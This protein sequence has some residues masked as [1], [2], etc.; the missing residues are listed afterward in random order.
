MKLFVKYLILI[1]KL[2]ELKT[3]KNSDA[4]FIAAIKSDQLKAP[5][6]KSHITYKYCS[7]A[8]LMIEHYFSYAQYRHLLIFNFFFFENM[9]ILWDKFFGP[10]TAM[11]CSLFCWIVVVFLFVKTYACSF[12][13]HA[14]VFACAYCLL[15]SLL[16]VSL[17]SS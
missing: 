3:G 13:L 7:V 4:S 14:F 12:I 6:K 9:I 1:S 5:L 17:F 16:C 2:H 10:R 15:A 8:V 11:T